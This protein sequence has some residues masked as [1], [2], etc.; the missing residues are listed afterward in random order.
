MHMPPK[1][2]VLVAVLEPTEDEA[3]PLVTKEGT[4]ERLA[5]AQVEAVRRHSMSMFSMQ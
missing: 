5:S 1:T 2:V 3:T 4:A